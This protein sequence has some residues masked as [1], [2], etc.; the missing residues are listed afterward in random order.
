[1][2]YLLGVDF[3]GGSSKATVLTEGGAILAQSEAEYPTLRPE[4]GAA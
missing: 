2:T 3:G 1:M 4:N